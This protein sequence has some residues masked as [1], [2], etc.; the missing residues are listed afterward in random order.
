MNKHGALP[1]P[2]AQWQIGKTAASINFVRLAELY[3]TELS[4]DPVAVTI[5]CELIDKV[6][7]GE[8]V[9]PEIVT[10]NPLA[11]KK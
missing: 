7:R 5:L 4:G 3:I 9:L 8:I 2:R 11:P 6:K 10:P 1:P